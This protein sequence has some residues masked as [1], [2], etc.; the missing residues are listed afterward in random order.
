MR[1]LAYAH[2]L[3]MLALI[4]LALLVLRE[5]LRIRR[6]RLL[7]RPVP[8]ARHRRWGRWVVLAVPLGL[9]SGIATMAWRGEPLLGSV[10]FRLAL[11]AALG[12]CAGGAL[13][14]RLERGAGSRLRGLHALLGATGVLLGLVGAVAGF[15][16][17][18]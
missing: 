5:G 1:W 2:P 9:A 8:S 3:L 14:L 16:I 10:H 15:A 18:P 11:G 6:G 4:A 13:G 7:G 12:L 17:L